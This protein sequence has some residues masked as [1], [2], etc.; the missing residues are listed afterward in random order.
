VLRYIKL[1]EALNIEPA[2]CRLPERTNKI[3]INGKEHKI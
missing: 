2:N 1:Q 3:K